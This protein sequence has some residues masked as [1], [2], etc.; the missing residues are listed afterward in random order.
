VIAVELTIWIPAMIG[1]GLLALVL[2]F[3]FVIACDKV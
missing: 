1:L 3:L 2:M